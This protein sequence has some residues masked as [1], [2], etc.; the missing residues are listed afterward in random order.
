MG[1]QQETWRPQKALH[2]GQATR[3]L[4]RSSAGSALPRSEPNWPNFSQTCPLFVIACES[5]S[6]VSSNKCGCSLLGDYTCECCQLGC[7]G[8]PSASKS[9]VSHAVTILKNRPSM[10]GCPDKCKDALSTEPC[11]WICMS[12]LWL[13]SQWLRQH[14]KDDCCAKIIL[15]I[16]VAGGQTRE[17]SLQHRQDCATRIAPAASRRTQYFPSD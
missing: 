7:L 13:K 1:F 9:H 6:V 2:D 14:E 12:Q 16:C 15:L 3:R 10:S 17:P 5:A 8:L 11:R 4:Q